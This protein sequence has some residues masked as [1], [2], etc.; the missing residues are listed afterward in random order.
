MVERMN[1]KIFHRTMEDLSKGKISRRAVLAFY[2]RNQDLF[3]KTGKIYHFNKYK[4]H[5]LKTMFQ[6]AWPVVAVPL[7]E[8]P[9]KVDEHLTS[10]SSIKESDYRG[11]ETKL[12]ICIIRRNSEV[13]GGVQCNLEGVVVVFLYHTPGSNI[14]NF[15]ATST[16]GEH[17]RSYTLILT[18][19]EEKPSVHKKLDEDIPICP[20]CG[21]RPRA[22]SLYPN[23]PPN[24]TYGWFTLLS[25][26]SAKWGKDH[27]KLHAKCSTKGRLNRLENIM[28]VVCDVGHIFNS[29]SRVFVKVLEQA[30]KLK[31][32]V[33][34]DNDIPICPK[35]G[36]RPDS[37]TL[38][39]YSLPSETSASFRLLSNAAAERGYNK[40]ILKKGARGSRTTLKN[41][42][43]VR[44]N[45][46]ST[47]TPSHVFTK[48]DSVFHKVLKQAI[49]FKDRRHERVRGK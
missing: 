17:R 3:E 18:E 15:Y 25:D 13:P 26:E 23:L 19:E 45:S 16:E 35:C 20:K 42:L 34:D 24:E 33:K 44:C 5:D 21:K 4:G 37:W 40:L 31:V 7:R 10:A 28:C 27:S 41:I 14:V 30:K 9:K 43:C 39:P 1:I 11:I 47:G 36:V 49:A 2:G 46:R 29:I 38:Y 22:W 12:G 32:V 48:G 6:S 8:K